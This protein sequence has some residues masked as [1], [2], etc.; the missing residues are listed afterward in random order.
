MGCVQLSSQPCGTAISVLPLGF[1][2]SGR[3]DPSL[4]HMRAVSLEN[5]GGVQLSSQPCGTAISVLPLGFHRSGKKEGLHACFCL[6]SLYARSSS[7]VVLHIILG[8]GVKY[9]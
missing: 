7:E 2:R 3:G 5:I 8:V 1:H 4:L 6:P 9:L